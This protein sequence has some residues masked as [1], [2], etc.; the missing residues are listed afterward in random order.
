MMMKEDK[1]FT[2]VEV[3]AALTILGIVFVGFMT[4]FPQMT[5]FNE[6][7][8][9]KLETMNLARQELDKIQRNENWNDNY[10]SVNPQPSPDD[11]KRW[12]KDDNDIIIEVDYYTVADLK[13]EKFVNHE[14]NYEISSLYK[15]H[16]KVLKDEK[17][18]SETFGYVRQ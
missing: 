16:I 7:T 10:I 15:V 8:E 1:G 11:Y 3:L 6:K 18:N 9:N 4:V 12:H 2:L 5:L 14:K 13:K 17:I